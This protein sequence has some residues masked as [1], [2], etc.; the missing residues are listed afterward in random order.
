MFVYYARK[1]RVRAFK[2]RLERLL[3]KQ[4]A[5]EHE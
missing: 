3:Q 4:V 1:A 5:Y 2:G